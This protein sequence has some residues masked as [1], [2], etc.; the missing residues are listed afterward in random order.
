[1]SNT[2]QHVITRRAAPHTHFNAVLRDYARLG[3]LFAHDGAWEGKQII[4]AQWMIE[5]TTVRASDTY[6]APARAGP[7]SLGY[8]YLVWLLPGTRRRFAFISD[9]GQRIFVDPGSKLV[10]VRRHRQNQGALQS[11]SYRRVSL[12]VFD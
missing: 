7:G 12:G 1:M 11:S 2:R 4:P 6:L 10:M 8:G 3:R 9:Y 5:A